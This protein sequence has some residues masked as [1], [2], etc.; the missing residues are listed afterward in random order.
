MACISSDISPE[1]AEGIY[2]EVF[3]ELAE[4]YGWKLPLTDRSRADFA[5]SKHLSYLH[6]FDRP[7]RAA[8]IFYGSEKAK[9]REVD[10]ACS[11]AGAA[12]HE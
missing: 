8:V 7:T 10:Y 12:T 1:E 5:I 6:G 3:Q 4:K 2:N 11:T 9:G